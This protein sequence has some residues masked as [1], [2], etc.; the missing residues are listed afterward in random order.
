MIDFEFQAELWL[1]KGDSAWHFVTV[2]EEPSSAIRSFAPE[3]KRGFGSVRVKVCIGDTHWQ[4]SVF[5]D[6]ASGN[7]FLPIKKSVRVAEDLSAGSN[8]QIR[9]EILI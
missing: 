3:A 1:W 5:P 9:L 7:Y 2:P 4:T 6:K 8:P